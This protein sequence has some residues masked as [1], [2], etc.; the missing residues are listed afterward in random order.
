[1]GKRRKHKNKIKN[2]QNIREVEQV[3]KQES[4]PETESTPAELKSVEQTELTDEQKKSLEDIRNKINKDA[5]KFEESARVIKAINNKIKSAYKYCTIHCDRIISA[6]AVIFILL[7]PLIVCSNNEKD[8]LP[9]KNVLSSSETVLNV[10]MNNATNLLDVKLVKLCIE[11]P[12]IDNKTGE[13]TE[14]YTTLSNFIWVRNNLNTEIN[15][16]NIDNKDYTIEKETQLEKFIIN[17]QYGYIKYTNA[18]DNGTKEMMFSSTKPV[19]VDT[20][21]IQKITNRSFEYATPVNIQSYINSYNNSFIMI[22]EKIGGGKLSIETLLNQLKYIEN[23]AI[24]SD[25]SVGI[26][27]N[28]DGLGK[29]IIDNKDTELIYSK[30]VLALRN[31]EDKSELLYVTSIDNEVV[32]CYKEDLIK[33][34]NNGLYITKDFE[35]TESNLYRTIGII[36]DTNLYVIKFLDDETE[37]DF[38]E[39]LNINIEDIKLENVQQIIT[40]EN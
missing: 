21:N 37:R 39:Q 22:S 35:N 2:N 20:S 30:G 14:Q 29:Y 13:K 9:E 6:L 15:K 18:G 3:E 33:T 36:A 24:I 5:E 40:L 1:M 38:C 26:S 12:I 16:Y 11:T 23:S 19:N 8:K 28:F 17:R 27:I 10:S 25:N 7:I 34:T 4:T 32:G 31:I